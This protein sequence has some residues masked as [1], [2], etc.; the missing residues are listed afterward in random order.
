M[1]TPILRVRDVDLSLRF[2]TQVLGFEGEG[3]LPGLDGRA[4][5]AEARLDEARVMLVAR[6][7]RR[8]GGAELYIQ[9]PTRIDLERFY[10]RLKA[11]TV[12][13]IDDLHD[14]LW[15]D[16]AFTII[17]P[18]AHRLTF[19]QAVRYPALIP[20]TIYAHSA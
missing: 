6:D 5:L 18:D 14:E 17:D 16:R 19:A 10:E 1:I 8:V 20:E 13:V 9:L 2:Y 15:G 12:C 3:G 4:V 7:D 11:R